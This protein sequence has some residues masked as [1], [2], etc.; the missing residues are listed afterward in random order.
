M[1]METLGTLKVQNQMLVPPVRSLDFE[2]YISPSNSFPRSSIRGCQVPLSNLVMLRN[3]GENGRGH[4]LLRVDINHDAVLSPT[5][6]F[7]LSLWTSGTV[8]YFSTCMTNEISLSSWEQGRVL[9]ITPNHKCD[10][11]VSHLSVCSTVCRVKG[12]WWS[13]ME[14]CWRIRH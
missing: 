1:L 14:A 7:F 8:G 3:T 12:V 13:V 4:E 9:G 11:S 5:A 6:L 2:W 10:F